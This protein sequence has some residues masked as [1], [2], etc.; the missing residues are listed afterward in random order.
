MPIKPTSKIDWTEGN[1][2]FGTVTVE[3]NGAKKQTGWEID[4]RPPRQYINW[5]FYNL[6]QWIK[7]FEVPTGDN[8]T[9]VFADSPITPTNKTR[10]MELDTTGGNILVNLP[11]AST[12]D[13]LE[14]LFW[15]TAAANSVTLDPNGAQ[16]IG[17]LSTLVFYGLNEAVRIKAAGTKWIVV[18]RSNL[19]TGVVTPG[20]YPYQITDFDLGLTVL[21]DS[22]ASRT[23]ILPPLRLNFTFNVKDIIGSL[24]MNN[25]TIQRAGSERIEGLSSNYSLKSDFGYWSFFCDSINWY[26]G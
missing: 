20:A 25:A 6:D 21:L 24:G 8:V 14:Y 4:E 12:V 5:L 16:L 26:K 22:S 23:I 2:S 17:G 10:W 18:S 11:E 19:N 3:P 15:K 1:P 9:K 7:Y 13:G